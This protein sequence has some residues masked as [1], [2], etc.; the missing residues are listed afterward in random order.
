MSDSCLT[1]VSFPS[2]PLPA[3]SQAVRGLGIKRG[4]GG[5]TCLKD[6]VPIL[7]MRGK[8]K[9][10]EKC[11]SAEAPDPSVSTGRLGNRQ[12]LKL[13]QPPVR[14]QESHSQPQVTCVMSVR[15]IN[16]S[17]GPQHHNTGSVGHKEQSPSHMCG[18]NSVGSY[19]AGQH[20]LR[21]KRVNAPC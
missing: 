14:R 2:H 5:R 20:S 8:D 4:E 15:L 9:F 10:L 12:D 11:G 17:S 6:K 16:V 3:P 21:R 18:R 7:G 19:E 1:R 13:W